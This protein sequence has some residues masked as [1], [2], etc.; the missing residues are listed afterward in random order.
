MLVYRRRRIDVFKE[1]VL[2]DVVSYEGISKAEFT[3]AIFPRIF[4]RKPRILL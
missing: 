1:I 4:Y 2:F 3:A